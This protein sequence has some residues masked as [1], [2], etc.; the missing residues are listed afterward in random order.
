MTEEYSDEEYINLDWRLSDAARREL[1]AKLPQEV[2]DEIEF[3]LNILNA[4]RSA[5]LPARRTRISNLKNLRNQLTNFK[6]LIARVDDITFWQISTREDGTPEEDLSRAGLE[7]GLSTYI[8][9]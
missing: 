7:G 8:A 5:E 4:V 2:I 9:G 1:N 3:E 6:T